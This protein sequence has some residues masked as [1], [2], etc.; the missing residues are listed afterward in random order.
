MW[1]GAISFGM[2]AIPV[3]LYL[4]TEDRGVSFHLLCPHCKGRIRNKRW[5]PH[6]NREIAWSEAVRG[7]E[8]GKDEYVEVS[9]ADLDRVPLPTARTIEIL[10]FCERGEIDDLFLQRPYYV[11]PEKTGARPYALLQEALRRSGRVAV[12]KIAFRDREHLV[13]I[14]DH[15]EGLLMHTLHWP[16]EIRSGKELGL[17]GDVE[18]RKPELDMALMLVDSLARP[19]DP[20]QFRDGYREAVDRIV[21]EKLGHGRVE[22]EPAAAPKVVDLMAALKASVEAARQGGT[23]AAGEAEVA[24][25]GRGQRRGGARRTTARAEAS[26]QRRRKAG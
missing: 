17:P 15:G 24:L 4:A 3:R 9:D 26:S 23:P 10:E 7:Y 22:H 25:S 16:D 5:C 14:A 1:T 21:Q 8:V 18:L 12:G 6:E 2:V 19:F 20:G 13:R 11:E